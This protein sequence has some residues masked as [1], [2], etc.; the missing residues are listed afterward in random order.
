[1]IRHLAA[2]A[3]TLLVVIGVVA[4]GAIGYGVRSFSEDGPL[5]APKRVVL[6]RGSGLRATS[7]RLEEE[8]VIDNG[9]VF[10][11]GARY[12][13]VAREIKYGEYEIPAGASMEEVLDIVVSGRSL[14]YRVTVA[15]GLTSWEIVELLKANDLLTGSI[16][17]VP[18]EG[19]LAPETYFISRG[20]TRAELIKRMSD[21]QTRILEEAW[22]AREPDTPLKS[23]AEA[24]T[25]ASIVEK[26][27]G[28]AS[29]RAK[30]AGV[31]LNRLRRGMRLQSDPTIIYGVTK[32]EGPL[33]RP[34]RQSDITR[35]TKYNTYVI[36]RLPPGPIANPGKEAIVAAVLPEQ[37]DALYFV[38]D[39]TG[40]HVFAETLREHERNVAAWRKIERERQN[41]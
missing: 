25:L 22:A 24:L 15:E 4:A 17:S 9:F 41:Q 36:D 5:A 32:G 7:E 27:T 37:T 35:S 28:V 29:E 21:A 12:R 34:I 3:M 33:D 18:P 19:S 6:E 1:M 10:R 30:V 23:M 40:G 16:E 11:L 13:G 31:F 38:A 14:Q 26:E 8:G 2:N 20:S 39:G